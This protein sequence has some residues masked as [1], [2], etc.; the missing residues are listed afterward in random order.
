M[1]RSGQKKRPF[2]GVGPAMLSPGGLPTYIAREQ[3][4]SIPLF[5]PVSATDAIGEPE[6]VVAQPHA[7]LTLVENGNATST[8]AT[9]KRC[10]QREVLP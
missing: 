2:R 7:V 9:G 8:K 3:S 6:D 5:R 4:V 1:T 10:P